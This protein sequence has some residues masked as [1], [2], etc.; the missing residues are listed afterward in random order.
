MVE[1]IM[2][3]FSGLVLSVCASVVT[4]MYIKRVSVND[5]LAEVE[6]RVL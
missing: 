4:Y 3:C 1:F 6:K 2:A 5:V